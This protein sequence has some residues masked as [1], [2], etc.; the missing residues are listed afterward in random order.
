LM[1]YQTFQASNSEFQLQLA[2]WHNSVCISDCLLCLS[3]MQEIWKWGRPLYL[4]TV[5]TVAGR[6]WCFH[7]RGSPFALV[8]FTESKVRLFILITNGYWS[9]A[10]SHGLWRLKCEEDRHGPWP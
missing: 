4:S 2:I 1:F 7:I 6:A 3:S 9:L 10:L 8:G 5:S